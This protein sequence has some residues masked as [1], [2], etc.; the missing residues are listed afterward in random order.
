[1]DPDDDL[2]MGE[3]SRDRDE[4]PLNHLLL[5]ANKAAAQTAAAAT[6]GGAVVGSE[7]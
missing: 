2:K 7:T 5:R 3:G 4:H 6:R 1:M